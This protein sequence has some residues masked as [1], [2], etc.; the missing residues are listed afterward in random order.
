MY[1]HT[2]FTHHERSTG[3]S[4]TGCQRVTLPTIGFLLVHCVAAGAGADKPNVVLILV[5]NV[6]YGDLGCYGN[7]EIKTPRIDQLAEQGVRCTDFYIGSPSCMPSRGA[8]L[9]GRS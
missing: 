5:D 3:Y 8:L 6:G 9:T 7:K 1:L 4:R 2:V